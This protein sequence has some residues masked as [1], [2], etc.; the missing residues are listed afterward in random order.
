MSRQIVFA[1]TL[2]ITLGV[3]AYTVYRLARFFIF[4][5]H[6][7]PVR[8]IGRRFGIMLKVAFGQT[9]IFRRPVVGLA[10]A[11]VFWGFCI[12]L[13][14]SIEMVIDG[15]AGTDKILSTLGG[16]YRFMMA[17]GDIFA[18]I[19][20][21]AVIIF[22]VRRIFMH[23]RRFEGIEM[24]RISHIDAIIALSLILILMLSL[25]GMNTGYY[26]YKTLTGETFH[27]IYP[28]S[29]L[30]AGLL[31]GRSPQA[32]HSLYAVCWWTH[33]LTIF[34]FANILPYSK[35]FH[36]FMSVP[37]VFLSRLEPL[38]QLINME[39]VTR[40]VKLMMNPD[41]AFAPA[42]AD[43]P[44]ERFGVKDAED[45]VWKTYLDSLSCTECGRCTSACPANITGK[46][47]SPR[48]VMMDLRARMKEKGPLMIKNGRDYNDNKSLLRDYITEE[49]LWACT[50]CNACARECPVNINHPSLIIDMR[51]YLVMEEG[52]APGEI[53]SVF[54]NIENNGAPWQFSAEDRLLWARDIG[55]AVPVMTDLFSRGE[56]PEYLYWVGC[57]GAFDD[58][59]KKVARAFTTILNHL[60]VSYAVLGKEETCTGDPA[61]RAG[62][63]MLF[64][65]QALQVIELLN[66]YGI[67]K[68]LTTCPHCYNVF[69]NEYPDLGGSYEVINYVQFLEHQAEEGRLKLAPGALKETGITYHDPCYLGRANEIYDEPRA[70]LKRVTGTFVEMD[71]NRSFAL[72]CGAGGAQMFKEAE[73]GDKEVFIER[74]EDALAT[75]AAVIATACPFCMTMLTDGLKYKNREE[76]IKNLDIAEIVAHSL[77]L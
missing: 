72:C 76:S 35:H 31:T 41:T 53:K 57:A 48:K 40:E 19:V 70:L 60:N 67:K 6:G 34:V 52:S 9:K 66:S 13:F 16:F 23:I 10:H 32:M 54:S 33:I 37:N 61:R 15:L 50:T 26:G 42:P 77:D 55:F 24:K 27:G 3:F 63:E 38:G 49:E 64:Q 62:N 12:I 36:V 59:Y 28:I 18:Y 4:T 68:I 22:L 44:A 46:R 39:N 5:R 74:T 14:G 65:M 30:V 56:K 45:V 11:L 51:R 29:T 75:D 71:R 1:L 43:V 2:L 20:A 69:R 17:A 73:K 47:L 7:F 21:A 25:I 8:H 58:R